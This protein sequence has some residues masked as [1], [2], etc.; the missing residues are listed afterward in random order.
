[1]NF[2]TMVVVSLLS[3]F[4]GLSVPATSQCGPDDEK[5]ISQ[6]M[7]TWVKD[8]NE[9]RMDDLMKL[10]SPHAVLLPADGSRASEKGEIRAYLEKQIGTKMELNSPGPAWGSARENVPCFAVEDGTYKQSGTG[11]T[12]EGQYLVMLLNAP[13]YPGPPIW[14]ITRQAFTAKPRSQILSRNLDDGNR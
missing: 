8:W 12:I 2:R 9:K 7:N 13:N 11:K 4:C 14:V 5:Q 3:C 10:Y 6:T 1:M